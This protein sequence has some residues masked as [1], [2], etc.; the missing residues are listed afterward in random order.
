MRRTG[1]HREERQA[2]LLDEFE[3]FTGPNF[4]EFS[5]SSRAIWMWA[6]E[7][8][9]RFRSSS[10]GWYLSGIFFFA[11]VTYSRKAP[12]VYGSGPLRNHYR[13]LTAHWQS[14][15]R[16]SMTHTNFKYFL[17]SSLSFH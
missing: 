17:D 16:L 5:P 2:A 4:F 13:L 10:H 6:C 8:W 15:T 9:K 3:T 14:H 7:R 1:A 12:Y 11:W